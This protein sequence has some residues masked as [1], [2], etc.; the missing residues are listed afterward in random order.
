MWKP[1]I[2]ERTGG[3]LRGFSNT[4][5]LIN[6]ILLP[7]MEKT[8]YIDSRL[9]TYSQAEEAAKKA[10]EEATKK[11]QKKPQKATNSIK[12]LVSSSSC[13]AAMPTIPLM[14]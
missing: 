14:C 10:T 1:N 11:P 9:V 4:A 7:N 5:T 2:P 13:H 8:F 6:T 3:E 12:H